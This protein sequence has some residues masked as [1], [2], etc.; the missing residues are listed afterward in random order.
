MTARHSLPERFVDLSG[1]EEAW[2]LADQMPELRAGY[3]ELGFRHVGL[4]GHNLGEG[5]LWVHEV[6]VSPR[7]DAFLTL[8]LHPDHP[9]KT[10][11]RNVPSAILQT[12]LSDGTVISTTTNTMQYR[13]LNHPKAGSYL[14]GGEGATPVELWD[15]HRQRVDEAAAERTGPILLHDAMP[16][17]IQIAQRLWTVG[18]TMFIVPL[19]LGLVTAVGLVALCIQVVEWFRLLAV[20]RGGIWLPIIFYGGGLIAFVG[21]RTFGWTRLQHSWLGG[22]WLARQFPWPRP[23]PFEHQEYGACSKP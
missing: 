7:Q 5:M 10:K 6:L 16:L 21:M 15:R 8:V 18:L 14:D 20:A 17:R 2:A 4:L 9:L 11:P 23:R 3:E 13:L 12:A 22:E 1:D 19:L